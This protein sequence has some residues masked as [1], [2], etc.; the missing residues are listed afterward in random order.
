MI[1]A[2][3]LASSKLAQQR[4]E[5]IALA[6]VICAVIFELI[7]R[8]RMMERYA[9]LWLMAGVTVLVLALWK[10]L[11]TTLSKAAGISYGVSGLFAI[12]FLFVLVMLVHFSMIVS[13]LSDQNTILAQRLALLQQRLE[14]EANGTGPT[15][16]EP[17]AGAEDQASGRPTA[18]G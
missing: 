15:A 17:R 5:V 8:K 18:P 6:V 2:V 12:T 13:R 16:G 4:V 10:G 7:R 11:L 9:L 3:T 1:A 14:Q